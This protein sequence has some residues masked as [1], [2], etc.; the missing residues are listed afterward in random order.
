MM[1]YTR[2]QEQNPLLGSGGK[3]AEYGEQESSSSNSGEEEDIAQH[4][5]RPLLS[6][7][8]SESWWAWVV[9]VASFLCLCVLDGISYTFGM[10]LTP[11]MEELQCGRGAIST[12]GSLQV[13]V[14]SMSGIF[15]SRLVTRYGSR[16]V[17]MAGSV[18]ASLGLVCASYSWSLAT[19]LV[20]YSVIT[21]LGFG[22]MY[23]SSVVAVAEHFSKRRSLAT[24]ICVC[25][26]GVGTFLLAPAQLHLLSS[27]GWRYVFIAMGILCC[28]CTL[29]G[30]AMT[31]VDPIIQPRRRRRS[32]LVRMDGIIVDDMTASNE[33]LQEET[34]Y[35]QMFFSIFLSKELLDS[36]GLTTFLLVAL[37]DGVATLA[38]FT[39]FT[40]LPDLAQ[41]AGVSAADAAF[42]I[43][44][45]GISSSAGRILSGWLCDRPWCDPILLTTAAVS[46][47]ALPS[48]LFPAMSSYPLFLLLSCLYGL[49]TGCW[50]SATSPLLVRVL[51]LHLLSPAFGL[52]TAVQGAAA[53]AGPPLAGAA[54]DWVGGPAAAFYCA[55]GLLLLATGGFLGAAQYHSRGQYHSREQ[56]HRI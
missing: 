11:L 36:P 42:L 53:L 33:S 15:A 26:T 20:S 37:A 16:A 46:S 25:G 1:P 2:E 28:L 47:A 41:S 50:I 38:L 35:L 14:Y 49:L 52:M 56:Y 40:F 5:Q 17:C 29:C 6:S 23:I 44:A 9:L 8:V 31:P 39:P 54:T 4:S 55:G 13:G 12:A 3:I 45:A 48:F 30:L 19:L 51:G 21:G 34:S 32:T 18:I 43:S 7:Q 10:F 27:V 22:L 24:G